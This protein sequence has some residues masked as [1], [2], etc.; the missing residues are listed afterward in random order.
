MVPPQ[1]LSPKILAA[2]GLLGCERT[3]ACLSVNACLGAPYYGDDTGDTGDTGSGEGL[4]LSRSPDVDATQVEHTP[5]VS[6]QEEMGSVDAV[7]SVI[8]RGGL[9]DDIRRR[10]EKALKP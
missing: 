8:G 4:C 7:S 10:I 2:L 9:P 5:V 6:P 3:S 1:H